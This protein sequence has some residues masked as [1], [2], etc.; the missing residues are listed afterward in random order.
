M[1]SAHPPASTMPISW[2]E[3]TCQ[4]F[5][6]E[7]RR[8]LNGVSP[9]DLCT[10]CSLF[11]IAL[12]SDILRVGSLTSF[13]CF[14]KYHCLWDAFHDDLYKILPNYIRPPA[15]PLSCVVDCYNNESWFTVSQPLCWGSLL[16]PSPRNP[17][18]FP[19]LLILCWASWLALNRM[20]QKR[21]F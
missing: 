17:L 4:I 12:L 3:I 10:C 14:F 8:D 7:T 1:L 20:W 21:R 15:F 6:L 19:I 13:S 16:F 11:L 18:Y 5:C 2:T 9:Q